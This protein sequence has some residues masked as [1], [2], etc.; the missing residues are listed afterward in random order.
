MKVQLW[1]VQSWLIPSFSPLTSEYIPEYFAILWSEASSSTHFFLAESNLFW[2]IL[3]RNIG[4]KNWP[5][6]FPKDAN[7]LKCF[8]KVK[9]FKIYFKI[10]LWKL[11]L[12]WYYWIMHDLYGYLLFCCFEYYVAKYSSCQVFHVKIVFEKKICNISCFACDTFLTFVLDLIT[13]AIV[14]GTSIAFASNPMKMSL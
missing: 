10:E 5:R 2:M 9:D 12:I 11:F 13:V 6:V 1:F 14:K 4:L 7:L 3:P 8:I